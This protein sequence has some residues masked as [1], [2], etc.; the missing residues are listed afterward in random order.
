MPLALTAWIGKPPA[1]PFNLG[2]AALGQPFGNHRIGDFFC[3]S[4]VLKSFLPGGS[5]LGCDN[6]ATPCRDQGED[7]AA[8]EIDSAVEK[9][10]CGGCL[11]RHRLA[12]L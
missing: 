3:A 9:L 11:K 12:A 10:R 4:A 8:D 5:V 1:A 7:R 6:R 2:A